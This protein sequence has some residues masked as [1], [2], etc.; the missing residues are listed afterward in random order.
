[1][2]AVRKRLLEGS[3]TAA[4]FGG[5]AMALG[6][7]MLPAVIG[8]LSF[9]VLGAALA[10]RVNVP[11]DNHLRYALVSSF[12]FG[13]LFVAIGAPIRTIALAVLLLPPLSWM[14]SRRVY[15]GREAVPYGLAIVVGLV[16]LGLLLRAVTIGGPSSADLLPLYLAGIFPGALVLWGS[17]KQFGSR[18]YH[19]RA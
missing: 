18:R 11:P 16:G 13:G 5:L 12:M 14:I 17:W 8:L 1:M 15:G 6:L 10:G 3:A 7:E 19:G 4:F 2:V 9:F